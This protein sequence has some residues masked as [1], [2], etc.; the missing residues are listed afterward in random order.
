MKA[1]KRILVLTLVFA[2]AFTCTVLPASAETSDFYHFPLVTKAMGNG[3]MAAAVAVQKFLMLYNNNFYQ[4][5]LQSGGTDGFFGETSAAVTRDFQALN[6]LD[7][8][9]KVG[10]LT[11]MKIESLLDYHGGGDSEGIWYTHDDDSGHN[12]NPKVIL[13]GGGYSAVD[14]NGVPTVCFYYPPR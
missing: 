8:D 2:M 14:Q 13:F 12:L 5:I 4:R 9:G 6:G 11:W 1:I 7:S 10:S 3:Y